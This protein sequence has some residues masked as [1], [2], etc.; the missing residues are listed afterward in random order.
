VDIQQSGA[1]QAI[2]A[3]LARAETKLNEISTTY[4]PNHPTRIQLAAQI[5]E[6]KEQLS[7]EMRRVS[8]A[9]SSVNRISGQKIAEL[10]Q[11]VETQKRTVL[12]LR[13]ERDEASVLLRDLETAQRAY[14]QVAQRRSQLANESQADQA[15]ARVLSPAVEPLEAQFPKVG[16]T[17]GM[18]VALGLLLGLGA[19]I[20]WELLD[21]RIRSDEDMLSIAGV[22]VLGVL[23]SAEVKS[24][25]VRRLPPPHRPAS[26]P[27]LTL[28]HGAR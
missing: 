13:A 15:S 8:G 11:L 7:K 4:G 26:P 1:V 2:K 17:L 3:D 12:G 6:L 28:D 24:S 9:T 20:G 16:N 19:A 22:P 21:R 25:P 5:A 23:G 27:Q 18:G 10:R 14:E